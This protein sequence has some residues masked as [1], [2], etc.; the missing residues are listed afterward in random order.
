MSISHALRGRQLVGLSCLNTGSVLMAFLVVKRKSVPGELMNTCSFLPFGL[1]VY[2]KLLREV[3][4]RSTTST[5]YVFRSLDSLT[6]VT[7]LFFRIRIYGVI[8]SFLL[9][10]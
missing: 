8:L 9:V 6:Y 2:L 3:V 10:L 4:S 5:E 7:L 1:V